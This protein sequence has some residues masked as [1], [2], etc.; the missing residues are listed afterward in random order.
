V[1][2]PSSAPARRSILAILWSSPFYRG[3]LLSLFVAGIGISAA[4]PQLSLFFVQELNASLPVAGA[5]YLTN[6]AAPF[7]GFMIGRL[8][9]RRPDRLT[10][11]RVCALVG[12]GGWTA[13]ALST[14][15]WMPFVISVIALSVAGAAGAQVF[16]AVR[17]ELTRHPSGMDN[18]IISSIRMAFTGGW[19]VGPVWAAG[20]AAWPGLRPLLLASA[21][22]ALL[23]ILPLARRHVSRHAVTTHPDPAGVRPRT[24]RPMG[25]MLIFIELCVLALSGDTLKVAFLPIYMDTV[26]GTPDTLRGAVIATQPLVELALIPL[27]GWAADR[28]GAQPIVII[29]TVLGVAA[30]TGYG[31]STSVGGL[32]VSQVLMAG[33]WATIAGLGVSV[34]QSLYPAGVGV[35]S[36]TFY[37]GLMFATAVGGVIGSAGVARVGMP[38]VFF[39]PAGLC[40]LAAVG[41]IFQ[42][43]R[44]RRA[45]AVPDPLVTVSRAERTAS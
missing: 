29:G 24:V 36:S 44:R 10:M 14:Q 38:A 16:A 37:S 19:I 41:M 11:F 23:Q 2:I 21:G 43:V 22:C 6:A 33:L 42:T 28:F 35:A 13:M 8:S 7:V 31:L 27:A 5:Y 34:A 18:R 4:V 1:H 40:A 45:V 32:F 20:S 26:L 17:D 30:N 15:I 9:D 39:I 3:A 25:P 12:A